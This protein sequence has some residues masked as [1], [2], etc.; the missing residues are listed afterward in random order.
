MIKSQMSYIFVVFSHS[1]K[2]FTASSKGW[3]L[4]KKFT[5]SHWDSVASQVTI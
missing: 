4:C 3:K 2:L 1:V 5:L